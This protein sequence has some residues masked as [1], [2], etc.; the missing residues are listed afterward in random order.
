MTR[1]QSNEK[2]PLA[3]AVLTQLGGLDQETIDTAIDAGRNGADAGWCG[4]TYHKDT[5]AFT[6]K[7]RRAIADAVKQ[8][9]DDL[10][11][12]SSLTMIAQFHC[13]RG[14]VCEEAIAIALFGGRAQ[15]EIQ[16]EVTL[17]ENALAWFALE[18]VGRALEN[19]H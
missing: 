7:H 4:F 8:T 9:A 19:E 17:V 16:G 1:K 13:L 5:C 10:G 2:H 6:K 15:T 18:E 3:I 12:L 14:G 11:E